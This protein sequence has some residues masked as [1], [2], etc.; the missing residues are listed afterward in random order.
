MRMGTGTGMAL[1]LSRREMLKGIRAV[2]LFFL[3]FPLYI[4]AFIYFPIF[5]SFFVH[6][7]VSLSLVLH[8]RL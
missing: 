6:I 3:L 2:F 4:F 5:L 1:L 7:L 8:F